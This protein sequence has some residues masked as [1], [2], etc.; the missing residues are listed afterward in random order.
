LQQCKLNF[1]RRAI[2]GFS[3]RFLIE[4]HE[5]EGLHFDVGPT[6]DNKNDVCPSAQNKMAVLFRHNGF[7]RD[8][9]LPPPRVSLTRPVTA[10]CAVL[11]IVG[12]LH[13]RDQYTGVLSCA[14]Q[15]TFSFILHKSNLPS[16]ITNLTCFQIFNPFTIRFIKTSFAYGVHHY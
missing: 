12:C 4:K 8:T 15:Q 3:A 10:R 1:I 13:I 7:S 16:M 14:W 2:W 5:P 9:E 11:T 6:P